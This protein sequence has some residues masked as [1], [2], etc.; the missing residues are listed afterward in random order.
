MKKKLILTLLFLS[1]LSTSCKFSFVLD[2]SE[3]SKGVS[4]NGNSDAPVLSSSVASGPISS[5]PS[6]TSSSTP[7]EISYVPAGYNLSWSDEFTD[8]GLNSSNWSAMIGN[9]NDYG[10]WGWG[11]NEQEYYK[12]ENAT[13]KDGL[14]H[15]T[16]KTEN[17]YVGSTLYKYSSARLRTAGKVSTTYGYIEAKIKMPAINGMWP[18]FWMLPESAYQGKGWPTSGEIDIMEARGR[19]AYAVGGTTHSANASYSDRYYTNS[20]RLSSSIS[21]WHVY[22]VLWTSEAM[23]YL[24]DGVAY[25]TVTKSQWQNDCPLYSGSAPFDQ[26]FHILLNLAVGGQ[27][28]NGVLPPSDFSSAEMGVDYVRIY[29]K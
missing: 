29:Q 25:N 26:P 27:Y 19:E 22:A 1:A 21:E 18:A 23:T 16:A 28:D 10:I 7:S 17:N 8:S 2:S 11:N 6:P 24:A 9:G 12:A 3:N 5:T 15:I 4:E 13:V 14:L 20:T